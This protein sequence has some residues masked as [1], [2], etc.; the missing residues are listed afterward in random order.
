MDDRHGC[1]HLKDFGAF[2]KERS[3]LGKEQGESLIDL[4]L[5]AVRLDLR[6]IGIKRQIRREIGRHT[7][8]HVEASFGLWVTVDDAT[9]CLIERTEPDARNR[10]LQLEVA[11]SRQTSHP[12]KHT[13]LRKES[14]DTA[15]DWRPDDGLVLSSYAPSDLEAPRMRNIATA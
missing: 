3:K 9:G 11:T 14:G 1:G 5:R 6:E 2:E 7:V 8:L 12:C 15:S 13:H 10:W 4:H